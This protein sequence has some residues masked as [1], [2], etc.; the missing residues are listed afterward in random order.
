M[1]DLFKHQTDADLFKVF[2]VPKGA[3][4]DPLATSEEPAK[5]AE[6]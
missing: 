1:A 2:N 4:R 3:G 5:L 6:K